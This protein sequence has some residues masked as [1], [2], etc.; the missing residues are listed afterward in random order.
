MVVCGA[1]LVQVSA[2]DRGCT[3]QAVWNILLA[4]KTAVW[5][6]YTLHREME[7]ASPD[8]AYDSHNNIKSKHDQAKVYKFK[9][10]WQLLGALLELFPSVWDAMQARGIWKQKFRRIVTFNFS[11]WLKCNDQI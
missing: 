2:S 5:D 9:G 3:L 11:K 1:V 6:V 10:K 8:L 7:G 4:H